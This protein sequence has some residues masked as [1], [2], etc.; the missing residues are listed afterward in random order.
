MYELE[1]TLYWLKFVTTYV[2]D[3]LNINFNDKKLF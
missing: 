1:I 2:D 3:P